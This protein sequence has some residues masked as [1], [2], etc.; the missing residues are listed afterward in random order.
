M[1]LLQSGCIVKQTRVIDMRT[2]TPIRHSICSACGRRGYIYDKTHKCVDSN[3]T[4]MTPQGRL[5][6]SR[7]DACKRIAER[8]AERGKA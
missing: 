5:K 6:P 7:V 2:R 8:K 3:P 1:R 4:E